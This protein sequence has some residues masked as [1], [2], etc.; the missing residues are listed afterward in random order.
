MQSAAI[1]KN[2]DILAQALRAGHPSNL[3]QLGRLLVGR[4]IGTS[5]SLARSGFQHGADGG[6]AGR[7][8]R[9]LRIE[10]KR[11]GDK[12]ALDDRELR[13]ENDDARRLNPGLE[14]WVLIATRA[15]D[16]IT[17]EKLRIKSNETGIPVVVID[18]K[19]GLGELPDLGALCGWGHEIVETVYGRRA[20]VAAKALA[21]VSQAH[22]LQLG[23][24]LAH[25]HIG[26]EN[27]RLKAQERLHDIW[28]EPSASQAA[29]GQDIAGG[30]RSDL[31][32]RKAAS[33][34]LRA[35]WESSTTRP[36][37]VH[38]AEGVGKTWAA[39]GWVMQDLA[40]LPL[41]LLLPSSAFPD[42]RS[43]S[44]TSVVDFLASTLRDIVR[45]AEE[46]Y[47]RQ[48]LERILE[49]PKEEGPCL[50][51]IVDGMNQEPSIRWVHF[52]Q[53]LQAGMFKD[54]VRLVLTTQTRHLDHALE[55]MRNVIGGVEQYAVE[56]YDVRSGGE[57]DE[58]LAKH[59]RSRDQFTPKLIELARVPRL[60]PIALDVAKDANIHG[61]ATVTRLL[62]A[63]GKGQVSKRERRA[64]TEQEWEAWLQELAKEY[65]AAIKARGALG[66]Q[67][68]PYR[69][70]EIIEQVRLV[71]AGQDDTL[72]RL[73]EIVDDRW[74][75]PVPHQANL[76]RPKEATIL[77]ALGVDLVANLE[78][79]A[80]AGSGKVSV[81]LTEWLDPASATSAAADILAAAVSIVVHKHLPVDSPVTSALV[82]ALLRSQNASDEHR[83]ELGA[84][85]TALST[86]LM[87]AVEESPGR[88]QA[89]ARTWALDSLRAIPASNEAAW[90]QIYDRMVS[91]VAHVTGPDPSS[92]SGNAESNKY[93][94]DRLIKSIGTASHGVHKVMGVPLRLHGNESTDLAAYVP[95]LLYGKPLLPALKVLVAASV[96]MC[97]DLSHHE[98]TG[99]EWLI[100]LNPCD[101]EE[102]IGGLRAMSRAARVD[103]VLEEG[104]REGLPV[105]VARRLLWLTL[106]GECELAARDIPDTFY[107]SQTYQDYLDDPVG[108]M[109]A[110]EGR[111]A[112]L[113]LEAKGLNLWN[114]L[115]RM[116]DFVGDPTL[117]GDASLRNDVAAEA[118]AFDV[119]KL[120]QSRGWG[121]AEHTLERLLPGFAR[122]AP[123]AAANLGRRFLLT[124]AER[125]GEAR[126]WATYDVRSYF[127]LS[128]AETIR[129]AEV[130]LSKGS[131]AFVGDKES[132][133]S[134]YL[135]E[136]IIAG[137]PLGEQLDRLVA[138]EAF[139]SIDLL[140]LTRSGSGDDLRRFMNRHDWSKARVREVL[141][142]YM[143]MRT[144]PDVD[145][146]VFSRV[147]GLTEQEEASNQRVLAFMALA[148]CAPQK[149]GRA[150]LDRKWQASAGGEL[151]E[152]DNGSIAVLAAASDSGLE[153]L[154][155]AVAPWTLLSEV[156]RRGGGPELAALAASSL[157]AVIRSDIPTA[158]PSTLAVSVD[159]RRPMFVNFDRGESEDDRPPGR[160]GL[161]N[162]DRGLELHREAQEVGK[163][164]LE[165]FKT[166]RIGM[167]VH[168]V[169]VEDVRPLVEHSMNEIER[170]IDG[171]EVASPQFVNRLNGAGGLYLAVCEALLE[172]N[173]PRAVPL[174]HAI[175]ASLRITYSGVADINELWHMPFRAGEGSACLE[176]REELYGLRRNQTDQSYL[177]LA[178][179]AMANGCETWLRGKIA[180]DA[181]SSQEWKRLRALTLDGLLGSETPVT[182][183]TW[184]TG[185]LTT[186]VDEVR[187]AATT[188]SNF[189]AIAKHWWHQYWLA[190]D[191]DHAYSSWILLC[192]YVDRRAYAWLH[193]TFQ[194]TGVTNELHRMKLLN[195]QVNEQK[196]RKVI[197]KN[198]RE[199]PGDMT[200]K[201]FCQ[202]APTDWLLKQQLAELD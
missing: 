6:T 33:R 173:S 10:C 195:I 116:S 49:R 82:L 131:G 79:E 168:V 51:I 177:E 12:T 72:R 75:E 94:S 193:E 121:Q 85:A 111:H 74:M 30:S 197:K 110:L 62:W 152:R 5:L 148:N 4:L 188:R 40:V 133:V 182:E 66:L 69:P 59:G 124:L 18:W 172:I 84:L 156:Q 70:G 115:G 99:F 2:L 186:T 153:I 114:R 81:S 157:G 126:Q 107:Q 60:F 89:S 185:L 158:P 140:E 163:A 95:Q 9:H 180:N 117:D 159:T 13:G 189:L 201:L 39:L 122:F 87:S 154:A 130:L 165:R 181:G 73:E 27:L 141:L 34:H 78:R 187:R 28:G 8:G 35:W 170:W 67:R 93:F 164:Y 128:T 145:E 144:V 162:P 118:D 125:S 151:L 43:I 136:I 146:L 23:R 100:L 65:W 183:L 108:S 26:Y 101:R 123:Y 17:Q 77:L 139:L 105:S 42:M 88:A 53:V 71:S 202:E 98:L 109:F 169:P 25:W 29:M 129:S 55:G 184:P 102:T 196:L 199:A 54:R 200:K 61:E 16:E 47:W 166:E 63:Y 91:W 19:A 38:G 64:F 22:V 11:Y 1:K 14:V 174:W 90:H 15:V 198:E 190:V 86:P 57:L 138:S 119:S 143:A 160:E 68:K 7:G 21:K 127:L 161:L 76:F 44:Q 175:D 191:A 41:C 104:V 80:E 3:E 46:S 192:E 112:P 178:I 120:K 48:R 37:A 83:R 36:I 132:I 32:E 167:G 24:E 58:M 45:G 179:C 56:P 31:I 171:M 96:A 106:D 194:P 135:L 113:A 97:I 52:V 142:N 147:L 176:L 155:D 20:G 149:F 137:L 50:L 92:P 134:L 103:V 150:L